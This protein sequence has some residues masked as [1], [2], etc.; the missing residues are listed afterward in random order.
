QNYHFTEMLIKNY[1]DNKTIF[2]YAV[3]AASVGINQ[4]ASEI[5]DKFNAYD[6]VSLDM[7]TPGGVSVMTTV[8]LNWQRQ[9]ILN[10]NNDGMLI[11]FINNATTLLPQ[12]GQITNRGFFATSGNQQTA[13]NISQLMA[14]GGSLLMI[15]GVWPTGIVFTGNVGPSSS[16]VI[17][18]DGKAG[19][20][21]QSIL[22]NTTIYDIHNTV[23]V[24]TSATF[25]S[26]AP[27]VSILITT[28]A[29]VKTT[30]HSVGIVSGL[31]AITST[32]VVRAGSAITTLLG[33]S[34]AL[35]SDSFST[36]T[37]AVRTLVSSGTV[38]VSFASGLAVADSTKLK[39]DQAV[40]VKGV[41]IPKF[42][43][44]W[45]P[46]DNL[47]FTLGGKVYIVIGGYSDYYSAE[48]RAE[49]A[50]RGIGYK[51]DE[52]LWYGGLDVGAQFTF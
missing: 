40:Q 37:L 3:G 32:V 31:A 29:D 47:T 2:N 42:S 1:T 49:A 11:G 41:I 9:V 22:Q 5:S 50:V 48:A 13:I 44:S 15:A 36:E 25:T 7:V 39:M 20:Y 35:S 23:N 38:A 27:S 17:V 4:K 34:V 52:L 46:L 21:Y 43:L 10:N 12:I 26:T 16:F 33:N 28:G 51:K 30:T 45:S 19:D 8:K 6:N 14:M 24:G 18:G